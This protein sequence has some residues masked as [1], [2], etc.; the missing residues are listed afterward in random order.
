MVGSGKILSSLI[1]LKHGAVNE[2]YRAIDI[3]FQMRRAGN[4]HAACDFKISSS[5]TVSLL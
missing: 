2:F 1:V 3:S 5:V 4:K